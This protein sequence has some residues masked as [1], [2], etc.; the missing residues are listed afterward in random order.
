MYRILV[1]V[2]AL[3]LLPGCFI[4]RSDTNTAIDPLKVESLQPGTH[5]AA[6]VTR[7]LG[8]PTEVVQLGRRSA[9]RYDYDVEKQAALWLL[10]I[11]LRGVDTRSDRVWVFFDEDG[12]LTHVGMTLESGEADY[13]LPWIGEDDE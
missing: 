10:I 8:G 2:A 13:E 7:I 9:Y 12:G 4:S 5:T 3:S 6:D 11:G 1:S